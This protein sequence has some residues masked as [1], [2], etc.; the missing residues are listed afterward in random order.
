MIRASITR[1]VR[2]WLAL[3]F[4]I[5]ALLSTLVLQYLTAP[6]PVTARAPAFPQ[7]N[8]VYLADPVTPTLDL[9]T[10]QAF[11]IQVVTSVSALFAAAPRATA[12]LIDRRFFDQV[13]PA[14]LAAQLAAGQIIVGLNVPSAWLEQI[15][16]YRQPS[17]PNTFRQDW[18]GRPF[19]SMVY[20]RHNASGALLVGAGSDKIN[21]TT[22]F[23]ALL[24][25]NAKDL[26][27]PS[28]GTGR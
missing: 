27:P 14:W 16:G 28:A 11:G 10:A 2:P 17:R 19:Y 25:N 18:G 5:V 22:G 8:A 9:P 3:L 24:Y 21:S 4:V 1:R 26:Q 13:P 20:Q 7:L 12:V 23:F 6:P 15:Q